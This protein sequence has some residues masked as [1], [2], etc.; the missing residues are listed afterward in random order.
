MS[1]SIYNDGGGTTDGIY[2][3]LPEMEDGGGNGGNGTGLDECMDGEGTPQEQAQEAA[4][5]KVQIAQAAQAARMCGKMSASMEKLV[6][7]V[8]NPKVD[9]RDVL[10]QFV[11]KCKSDSRSWARPNRR[12]ITQ[13]IYLPERSGESMGPLVFAVDCSGS[14]WGDIP[15]F[16]NEVRTVFEDFKPRELHVIYFDSSVSHCD[17]FEPDDEF[18]M[19]GHGGGGTAFSPIFEKVEEIGVEAEACIILTDLCC[20]DFGDEP[21]Y[22]VLWVSNANGEAP[23]GEVV[24]M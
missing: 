24:M 2:H 4:D 16:A 6:E 17:K 8:L 15:Q 12:F 13:G 22:P 21:E 10:Q 11:V 20:H 18:H 9:W 1:D 19:E 3:I 23:F 14:C 7:E 5:W